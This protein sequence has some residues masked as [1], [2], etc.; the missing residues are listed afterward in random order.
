MERLVGLGTP[1][2]RFAALYQGQEADGVAGTLRLFYDRVVEAGASDETAF[3]S[4][5]L[6]VADLDT[7][8][9]CAHDVHRLLRI[10]RKGGFAVLADG[11]SDEVPMDVPLPARACRARITPHHLVGPLGT[12]GKTWIEVGVRNASELDWR[13]SRTFPL[14]LGNRWL[15]EDGTAAVYNDARTPLPELLAAGQE[16][17]LR[18][19]VT[20]PSQPGGYL[21]DFDVV[22]EGLRWFQSAGSF[23][24][25]I[26][27][28]VV[29]PGPEVVE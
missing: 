29:R 16:K 12:G 22:Q 27:V 25:R 28:K 13:Q 18:L 5:D 15:R 17:V 9:V 2:R 1:L 6:V 8:P 23:A 11:G 26:P 20:A 3:G 21:L 14:T 7:F 19:E 24:N 10:T 4:F